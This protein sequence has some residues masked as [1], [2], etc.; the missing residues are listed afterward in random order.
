VD[1]LSKEEQEKLDQQEF[2]K[3]LDRNSI[4]FLGHPYQE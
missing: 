3:L 1:L 4:F 2:Q